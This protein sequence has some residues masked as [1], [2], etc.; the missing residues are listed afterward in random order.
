[1]RSVEQFRRTKN[2]LVLAAVMV[3]VGGL[4]GGCHRNSGTPVTAPIV[5][6]FSVSGNVTGL[7]TGAKVTL[8]DNGGDSLT[9]SAD[10]TFT[11]PILIADN[12][13]YSVTVGSQPAGQVCT[14]SSGSGSGLVANVTKVSVTCSANSVTIG[15]TATGLVSGQPV[16][17]LNNGTDP[18]STSTTGQFTFPTPLAVGGS[19]AITVE[20]QPVGKTCT[21]SNGSGTNVSANVSTISVTCSSTTFA[22]SGTITGLITGQQVTLLNNGADATTVSST[23]GTFQFAT[24]VA[25]NGSYTV[26]VGTQP[27]AEHC[28]VT[29]GTG[30]NVQAAVTTVAV[31]CVTHNL[32]VGDSGA[33]KIYQYQTGTGPIIP[34]ATPSVTTTGNIGNLILDNSRNYLY[35]TIPSMNVIA[36]FNIGADGSLTPMTTAT[37]ASGGTAPYEEALSPNGKWLFVGDQGNAKVDSFAIGVD[38]SLT[39]I[40]TYS[41]TSSC[42]NT[43]GVVVDASSTHLYVAGAAI[44]DIVMMTIAAD[45]SLSSPVAISNGLGN[46]GELAISPSGAFLLSGANSTMEVFPI[47]SVDGTL[48]SAVTNFQTT[49]SGIYPLLFN[50]N[51][52]YVGL[53]GSASTV[54][55]QFSWSDSTYA[56]ALSPATVTSDPNPQRMAADPTGTYM[57]VMTRTNQIIDQYL[58]GAGGVLTYHTSVT[59]LSATDTYNALAV[60]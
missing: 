14:V 42:N 49:A 17:L 48:G 29:A 4:L 38:G 24:Q 44:G 31:T 12:G 32:Y 2:V 37:V 21:V 30:N 27:T 13:S 7:A 36:Q 16:T 45:G 9:V 47:S 34:L 50:G 52:L 18:L 15:G 51:Y 54:V 25:Y 58:I 10:G 40:G 59:L 20:T 55:D 3:F 22:V 26:S 8:L 60:R 41:C 35:A 11:F 53:G 56:V 1:M 57:F 23:S 46:A 39:H 19:Y 6:S 43:Q 33:P 28:S 5:P